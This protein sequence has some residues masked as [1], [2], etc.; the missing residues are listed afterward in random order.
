M[1]ERPQRGRTEEWSPRRR[2]SSR[3]DVAAPGATSQLRLGWSG[4]ADVFGGFDE[5][6]QGRYDSFLT[7][8]VVPQ[9]PV[10]VDSK[11]VAALQAS[12]PMGLHT[13]REVGLRDIE[14]RIVVAHRSALPSAWPFAR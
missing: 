7:A 4:C 9:L 12:I 8:E 14:V 5:C 1:P 13:G 10:E 3:G 2:R 11:L 6:S